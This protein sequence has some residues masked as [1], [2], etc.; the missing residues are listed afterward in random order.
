MKRILHIPNYYAPHIGGIEDVCH[1]IISATPSYK[2]SVL[3]F[4]DKKITERDVVEGTDVIRC[5]VWKK[6][7]SQS[8]SFSMF[9]EMKRAFREIQPDIVHFHTPNPLATVLL[10]SVLPSHTHLI[11]HWHSDII[12]Q[13]KLY[14]LFR[15]VE[16]KLLSRADQIVATA[17]TYIKGSEAL[18]SV[19][20]KVRVIPNTVNTFKLEKK[21]QDELMITSIKDKY[22]GK[23]IVFTFG[24]HV[25]YKGLEHLV[26]AATFL[27]DDTVLVIAGQGPLTGKL[28]SLSKNN[29][30]IYFPGRLSDDELRCYL[31]AADVFAFPSITRNEAFGIALAE[32]MYC[33]LPAV[34]FTIANSGV[35]WVCPDGKTGLESANGNTLEL[36]HAL[37]RLLEN[38]ELRQNL[39]QGAAERAR[40]VFTNEAIGKDLIELYEISNPK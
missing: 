4:N 33:G 3:C 26:D 7:F 5:G 27:T 12:E 24:R 39:S 2:H 6:L 21:E 38:N 8:V 28:K 34:T 19:Y 40:M 10:I 1:S 31:Y 16:T 36:A 23:R 13:R 35:N 11:V 9:S 14:T 18:M 15:P 25:P 17:P 29:Q 32:A 37:N 20:G 22:K 30:K